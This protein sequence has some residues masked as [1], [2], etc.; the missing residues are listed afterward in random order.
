MSE[1]KDNKKD[2][3]F[4]KEYAEEYKNA[5]RDDGLKRIANKQFDKIKWTYRLKNSKSIISP[6]IYTSGWKGGSVGRIVT[7]SLGKLGKKIFGYG[8]DFYQTVKS[9]VKDGPN[10]KNFYGTFFSALGSIG[11]GAATGAALGSFCPGVGNVAGFFIGAGV[12]AIGSIGGKFLGE[13][14][15][16]RTHSLSDE[17]SQNLLPQKNNNNDNLSGGGDTGGIEFQIPKEIDNF[18]KLLYF[19]NLS[20]QKIVFKNEFSNLKDIL[21]VANRFIIDKNNKFTSVNQVF[22]T[23]LS[24]LYGGFIGQGILP[25]VSLNFN[26]NGILYSIMPNYYKK[27]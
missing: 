23:I 1:K 4:I 10:S 25:Y 12:S 21:D 18:K 8:L 5:A 14:L 19:N 20:N 13:S 26:N 7:H 3:N 11:T 17:N 22:Q 24:E 27:L 2:T 16:D 9:F 15:Y 6:K